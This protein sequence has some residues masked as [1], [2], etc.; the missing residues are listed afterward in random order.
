M[1]EQLNRM[2]LLFLG[3]AFFLSLSS[4]T[5]DEEDKCEKTKW[6]QT[7][8]YNVQAKLKAAQAHLPDDKVLKEATDLEC[9]VHIYKIHCD[10]FQGPT[11]SAT[12]H[13][14]CE[15]AGAVILNPASGISYTPLAFCL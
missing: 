12:T 7:I 8:N 5:K 1:K 2:L 3:A 10:G 6:D 11:M 9:I 15:V 4:C 13:P 14:E